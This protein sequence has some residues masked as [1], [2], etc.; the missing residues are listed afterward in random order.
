MSQKYREG[1]KLTGKAIPDLLKGCCG[2]RGMEDRRKRLGH[3]G[4]T[5]QRHNCLA[6]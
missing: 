4:T 1:A 6:A 5:A 2:E 3:D